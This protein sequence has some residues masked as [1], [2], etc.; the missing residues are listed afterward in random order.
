MMKRNRFDPVE[1][2]MRNRSIMLLIV[3]VFIIFGIY[4][5]I[6]M[7]KNEFP[8]FT[9]RTGVVAAVYPGATS[10][11]VEEQVTKPLEKFLWGFKEIKKAK[12]YSESKDGVCYVFVELNDD[13][14][15]KDEFWSKFK[16]K[17]QQFKG[18]LPTGVLALIA[19]DDFGDTSAMLVT[20]ESKDKTYRQLH[21]YMTNLQDSLRTIPEVANMR[22]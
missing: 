10:A 17:L 19:N 16:I 5:L 1:G 8:T 2:V 18:E 12:T 3:S 9:V 20:L 21:D 7:P 22:L 15:N 13:I 11:E 6:N 14:K 4:S